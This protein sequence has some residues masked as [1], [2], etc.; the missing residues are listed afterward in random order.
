MRHGAE[1]VATLRG[2][3]RIGRKRTDDHHHRKRRNNQRQLVANHLCDGAHRAEHREFVVAPPAGHEDGELSRGTDGEEKENAAINRERRHVSAIR[4][5]AQGENRGR[6][7]HDWREK[8]HNLVRAH[9]HDVFLDEHLDAVCHRLK[10]P[11]WP[12]AIWSV[13]ILHA[14]EN[15]PFEHRDKRKER[16]KDA[17]QR[18]NI[19]EARC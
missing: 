7:D 1:R 19:D 5:H 13:A 8:M 11:E 15:L 17:E 4:N 14:T 2:D 3:N 9:W 18:K 16:E 6:G 12:N 10:K